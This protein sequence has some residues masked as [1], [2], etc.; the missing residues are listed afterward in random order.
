MGVL[1]LR[2]NS[3]S[4]NAGLQ[5]GSALLC[6]MLQKDVSHEDRV[7][8]LNGQ[9]KPSSTFVPHIHRA[10]HEN[11][12]R[13]DTGAARGRINSG[14]ERKGERGEGERIQTE[15]M[16]AHG[17]VC[18][19]TASAKA[20]RKTALFFNAGVSNRHGRFRSSVLCNAST[21][22]SARS[23]PSGSSRTTGSQLSICG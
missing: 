19:Q 3:A 22:G 21:A 6:K 17:L 11:G 20:A 1:P 15:A 8:S 18:F 9:L 10:A 23:M 2:P 16:S 14:T 4:T 12:H 5:T 13:R 7:K